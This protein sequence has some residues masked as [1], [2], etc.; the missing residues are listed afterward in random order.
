[1]KQSNELESKCIQ[2]SPALQA[3]PKR[4]LPLSENQRRFY[5]AAAA[6]VFEGLWKG[7]LIGALRE[8]FKFLT[9]FLYRQSALLTPSSIHSHFHSA[10]HSKM[11]PLT[12][13]H[14]TAKILCLRA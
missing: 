13:V 9:L 8:G 2:S 6:R 3:H 4:I 12:Q 10:S 11:H 14:P 7:L 1:M 5:S